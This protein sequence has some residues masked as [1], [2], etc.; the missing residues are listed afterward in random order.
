MLIADW[1]LSRQEFQDHPPV[2]VDIGASGAINPK[3]G[4]IARHSICIAFDADER[5]MAYTVNETS[6]FR[7]LYVFNKIVTNQPGDRAEFHLTRSPY[8]SSLL[9][10]DEKSL[11]GWSFA[12]L[13]EIDR[14]V[15]LPATTLASAL[16]EIGMEKVDWFKTDSQGI[17]LRLFKSLGDD[18][19]RRVL[20]AEFEP[21]IIDAYAGEDKLWHV[22]QYMDTQPFWV[23]RMNVRGAH[24]LH[25]GM[26]G[27]KLKG[28]ENIYLRESPVFAELTYANALQADAPYLCKRDFLLGYLFAV[29]EQQY[30]FAL[31]IAERGYERF[32]DESFK[33]LENHA[34]Q[35]LRT[36]DENVFAPPDEPVA[37][38]A[39]GNRKNTCL[40]VNTYY[41][42]FLNSYYGRNPSLMDADYRTQKSGLVKAFFGDSDFYSKHLGECGWET[43]D[44]IINNDCMQKA[45]QRENRFTGNSYETMIE[46][47]RR[48]R[49]DVVYIQNLHLATMEFLSAIRPYVKLIAG[50]I[51]YPASA[52]MHLPGMD[53]IFSS[54]P[55]FVKRFRELGLTAYY[56]SLAFD[57]RVLS[58][59]APAERRLPVT[60]VGGL[61]QVHAGGTDLLETLAGI[62]PVE[63]WGYGAGLLDPLSKI[64][65]RHHGEAWGLDMF[66]ILCRSKITIN[67]HIDVAE[68]YANNMRLFEATGCGALLITDY[69]DNLNDLFE[70][71][72]EVV[73]YRSAGECAALIEYYLRYPDEAEAIA[74]AGQARTLSEHSYRKSMERTAAILERHLRRKAGSGK[75]QRVDMASVSYGHQEITKEEV[76]ASLTNAWRDQSIPPRQR[77]LVD[78]QL[79]DMYR[80][81]AAEPFRVLAEMLKPIAPDGCPLLEIGCASGYYHEVLEYLLSRKLKYAGVDY[82]EAM[83]AMAHSHYPG[84]PFCVA[85]GAALP[86]RDKAFHIAISSCILLHTPDYRNHIAETARVAARYAIAHRTPVCRRRET[87]YLKKC[88]YGVETVELVFNEQEL[89][90]EFSSH[91]FRVTGR[92]E[93]SSNPADDRYEIN[94]LFQRTS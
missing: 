20:V 85:D 83:I 37:F 81:R 61:S 91:G 69:K 52:D 73:A 65:Q 67:R 48:A 82:S 21:G 15:T 63:F 79:D 90:N 43:D 23:S 64:R 22:L 11:A 46:Q 18:R 75:G 19:I 10:P 74:A 6:G 68:N 84:V 57:S 1:I 50:Q 89:L 45:W 86:Y 66:S 94:Y 24:R 54:F 72:R 16:K 13:F 53:V 33:T 80:G 32:A 44:L 3:W 76:C 62:A 38:A 28:A 7:K 51:A 17:D 30:G 34:L 26:V 41:E 58:A 59:V 42:G 88:A 27:R 8:C 14:T 12:D 56:Q 2:L 92:I 71:G 4:S 36:G 87:Q 35:V 70:I 47:I 29:I 55:H 49:P 31:E 25:S 39:A 60:F 77:A 93:Y 5:E 78:A 9:R 40:F